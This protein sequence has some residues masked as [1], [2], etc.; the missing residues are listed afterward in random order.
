[1]IIEF[2]TGKRNSKSNPIKNVCSSC[3][4]H[5]KCKEEKDAKSIL[6]DVT[7]CVITIPS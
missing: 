7:D 5:P 6:T 3:T 1:M 4:V 2:S